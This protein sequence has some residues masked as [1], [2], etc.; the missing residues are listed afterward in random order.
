MMD[1]ILPALIA[2]GIL[3]AIA[4]VGLFKSNASA[5]RLNG[6]GPT[7]YNATG[8]REDKSRMPGNRP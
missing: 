3:L 4:V 2:F 5:A 7:N 8:R 6:S 1:S